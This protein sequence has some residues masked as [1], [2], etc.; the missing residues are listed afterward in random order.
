MTTPESSL[1]CCCVWPQHGRKPCISEMFQPK[2]PSLLATKKVRI[3]GRDVTSDLADLLSLADAPLL[4]VDIE[5][6]KDRAVDMVRALETHD[7]DRHQLFAL[8]EKLKRCIARFRRPGWYIELWWPADTLRAWDQQVTDLFPTPMPRRIYELESLMDAKARSVMLEN[9]CDRSEAAERCARD[10]LLNLAIA[11]QCRVSAAAFLRDLDSGERRLVCETVFLQSQNHSSS[12]MNPN[13]SLFAGYVAVKDVD[14]CVVNFGDSSRMRRREFAAQLRKRLSDFDDV[15]GAVKIA[16]AAVLFDA[17]LALQTSRCFAFIARGEGYEKWSQDS[18]LSIPMIAQELRTAVPLPGDDSTAPAVIFLA[19]EYGARRAADEVMSATS[20]LVVVFVGT[21]DPKTVAALLAPVVAEASRASSKKHGV[22]NAASIF[23]LK[24][25]SLGLTDFGVRVKLLPDFRFLPLKVHR[26]RAVLHGRELRDDDAE[27]G[28][29]CDDDDDFQRTNLGRQPTEEQKSWFEMDDED[30]ADPPPALLMT[31]LATVDLVTARL[32]EDRVV[33]V[34]A[35]RN[36]DVDRARAVVAEVCSRIVVTSRDA[37]VWRVR[38]FAAL[39]QLQAVVQDAFALGGEAFFKHRRRQ[40]I[41]WL[42]TGAS[43]E[44]SS[45]RRGWFGKAN[46]SNLGNSLVFDAVTTFARNVPSAVFLGVVLEDAPPSK[47]DKALTALAH[48]QFPKRTSNVRLKAVDSTESTAAAVHVDAVAVR[49]DESKAP[50]DVADIIDTALGSDL[51]AG[52]YQHDDGYFYARVCCMNLGQ[53]QDLRTLVM[54]EDFAHRLSAA[55]RSRAVLKRSRAMDNLGAVMGRSCGQSTPTPKQSLFLDD[56]LTGKCP[57]IVTLRGPAGSGKTWAAV[58]F[59]RDVLLAKTEESVL[60]VATTIGLARCVI[61]RLDVKA[62]HLTRFAVLLKRWDDGG[63]HVV[64]G[65]DLQTTYEE[66]PHRLTKKH[67]ASAMTPA[68]KRRRRPE[69]YQDSSVDYGS[70]YDVVII[71][72]AHAVAA[73]PILRDTLRTS[74]MRLAKV[75]ARGNPRFVILEDPSNRRKATSLTKLLLTGVV[76]LS[77]EKEATYDLPVVLRGTKRL[78][79]ASNVYRMTKVASHQRAT[80]PPVRTYLFKEKSVSSKEK[81]TKAEFT[82][83]ARFVAEAVRSIRR[84]Y[85]LSLDDRCAIVVPD[86]HFK[87]LLAPYLR[88]SLEQFSDSFDLVDAAQSSGGTDSREAAKK[89]SWSDVFSF[90]KKQALVY[91]V[92]DQAHGIEWL[93]VIA[94]GLDAPFDDDDDRSLLARERIYRAL[95]RAQLS[96]IVVNKKLDDAWLSWLSHATFHPLQKEPQILEEP[97]YYYK[98]DVSDLSDDDDDLSDDDD[99]FYRREKMFALGLSSK[100][101]G[102]K[103]E[104]SWFST[105]PPPPRHK[106]AEMRKWYVKVATTGER[107][108]TNWEFRHTTSQTVEALLEK[109]RMPRKI[110][111]GS[112]PTDA[113][114]TSGNELEKDDEKRDDPG[115]SILTFTP[116]ISRLLRVLRNNNHEA[117][118]VC[119]T[120]AT[121]GTPRL[122]SAGDDGCVRIWDPNS[123]ESPLIATYDGHDTRVNKVVSFPNKYGIKCVASASRDGTIAVWPVLEFI[124]TTSEPGL[125]LQ[126]HDGR[127]LSLVY[128]ETDAGDSRLASSSTDRT[129]RIWDADAATSNAADLHVIDAGIVYDICALRTDGGDSFAHND[130]RFAYHAA[131]EN[132]KKQKTAV[133]HHKKK[134][135]PP[136]SSEESEEEE[137]L[138]KAKKDRHRSFAVDETWKDFRTWIGGGTLQG[139]IRFWDADS[140]GVADVVLRGHDDR[141]SALAV[142]SRPVS[143][144]VDLRVFSG[145]HDK[146]VRVWD[147]N[148]RDPESTVFRGHLDTVTAVDAFVDSVLSLKLASA[149]LD[150]TIRIWDVDL[151][152]V[153]RIFSHSDHVTGTAFFLDF[154]IDYETTTESDSDDDDDYGGDGLLFRRPRRTDRDPKK[155]KK[156]LASKLRVASSSTDATIRIWDLDDYDDVP[157]DSEPNHHKDPIDDDDD[158]DDDEPFLVSLY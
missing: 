16:D 127:V 48:I 84:T 33:R 69:N 2:L 27:I 101:N 80:G 14:A 103:K 12:Y 18:S 137:V 93:F 71:D 128:F 102:K 9:G 79:D 149:S 143:N 90:G 28:V 146:D 100:L 108:E 147:M 4:C 91:D 120:S 96:A 136:S 130:H 50:G 34:V 1:G 15:G 140:G 45:K 42:D 64:R 13:H 135:Q 36:V 83:Y 107:E 62:C 112:V 110:I 19:M 65:A 67:R 53:L 38:S 44:I 63:W 92:V 99:D 35:E 129:I 144:G 11:R 125:R 40:V 81:S 17:Q 117:L 85:D 131:F 151:G 20:A 138:V 74:L 60:Y 139:D 41:V 70:R 123:N 75:R 132:A 148:L 113:W 29:I 155:K 73:A 68:E 24:A 115:S 76:S 124:A 126:G 156:V 119:A 59:V 51:T 150:Q 46:P 78:V 111:R 95:T 54:D 109:K 158:D 142:A 118:D 21:T 52:V 31:D 154:H 57:G 32:K 152:R 104:K 145:S 86:V 89:T 87:N 94:V 106:K 97:S 116:Y 6:F 82:S 141:I 134:Q 8:L 72:E 133:H 43:D 122:A 58:R 25:R 5:D 26:R 77:S 30:A 56:S 23:K 105:T 49:F 121:D 37:I 153:L 66:E 88:R 61:D 7:V 55:G 114:E 157:D 47:K 3:R 39:Q 22:E 98:E 10:P